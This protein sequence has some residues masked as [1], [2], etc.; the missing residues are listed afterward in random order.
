MGLE[1]GIWSG[2]GVSTMF[3]RSPFASSEMEHGFPK[4]FHSVSLRDFPIDTRECNFT[5]KTVKIKVF[6]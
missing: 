3:V 6:Q 1:E 4:I 5:D 2:I